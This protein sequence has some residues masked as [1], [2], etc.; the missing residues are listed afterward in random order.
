MKLDHLFMRIYLASI[1]EK[2]I[3]YHCYSI[4]DKFCNRIRFISKDKLYVRS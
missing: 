1:Y 2:I 4:N 3:H